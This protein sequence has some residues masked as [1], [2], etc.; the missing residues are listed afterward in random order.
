MEYEFTCE[1][2]KFKI[3][4]LIVERGADYFNSVKVC[5]VI[6]VEYMVLHQNLDPIEG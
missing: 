1:M 4:D 3:G 2:C 5:K 6:E